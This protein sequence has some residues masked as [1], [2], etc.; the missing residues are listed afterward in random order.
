MKTQVLA[1]AA[2][3]LAAACPAA[4]ATTDAANVAEVVV[5]GHSVEDTLPEQLSKSGVRVTVIPD[6]A[7]LNGGYVDVSQSLQALAPGL[8]IQSKNGPFDYVDISFQGSRTEDVLWMVDGVRINNRLYAGTTPLDTLPSSMVDRVE[9]VEGGQSLFYGTS[10]IAGAVNI[11]TRPFTDNLTALATAGGDTNAGVHADGV[12]SNAIGRSQLVAFGSVD[13]SDGYLAFRPEDYQPSSTDRR[14]SYQVFTLGGKYAYKLTD[15]LRVTASYWR[16]WA[17]LDFAQPYRVAKNVN[18]RVEDLA[19]VKAEYQPMDRLSFDVKGY[20]HN[21]STHYDT[22]YNDLADPG[23]TDV[24]YNH[25]FWGFW[26]YGVNLL[27]KYDFSKSLQAYFGYDLQKYGG[28]DEVL[29]IRQQDETTH[30]LFGQLRATPGQLP[31][32]TLTAGFRYNHPDV[33]EDDTI[34]NVSGQYDFSPA[35]Y[36]KG[37]VGTNFRLPTA[38]ELFADDPLDERGNPNLKP[39]KSRSFNVAVGGR[40]GQGTPSLHWA[41]VGFFRDIN[42]LIDFESFD[43][44]TQQDVFGNVPGTVKVRGGEAVLDAAFSEAVSANFNYTYASSKMDGGA[45]T[46]RVPKSV[47]KAS[48]DYHPAN[49]PIGATATLSYTGAVNTSV[50]GVEIPYGHYTVVDLSGRYFIDAGRHHELILSLQNA[51]DTRYG[52]PGRGCLD[53]STDGPFD[54][55]AP[56]VYVNRGLPRTLRGSYLFRF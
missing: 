8:Y 9:V 20:Y 29:V 51:F 10:A 4:A 25:A 7:I 1:G 21:W 22:V 46:D 54:C 48:L 34:W 28:R 27:G 43:P 16:T 50:G 18:S 56:Y 11:V 14:R 5:T 37:T 26:D 23:K 47:L 39:E 55:S 15:D 12:I 49:L 6:T 42:N 53:V 32:L 19:I 40:I 44:V 24:L 13:K 2:M 3:V 35:L 33:G 17:D 41:L 45:Q 36:V 52:R 30:A 38:E 31:G